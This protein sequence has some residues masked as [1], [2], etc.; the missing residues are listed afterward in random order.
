MY[1]ITICLYINAE[2]SIEIVI[3]I[4]IR[5]Y[6]KSTIPKPCSIIKLLDVRSKSIIFI[7]NK[8]IGLIEKRSWFANENHKNLNEKI[9]YLN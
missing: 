1:L 8:I 5:R 6:K 3:M 4:K 9:D 2:N 7:K